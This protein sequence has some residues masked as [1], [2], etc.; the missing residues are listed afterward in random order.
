LQRFS[1]W[2]ESEIALGVGGSVM[3]MMMKKGDKIGGWMAMLAYRID[4]FFRELLGILTMLPDIPEAFRRSL[5]QTLSQTPENRSLPT[6]LLALC[7]CVVLVSLPRPLLRRHPVQP[8]WALRSAFAKLIV[9][10]L[11]D[12]IAL[13]TAVVIA[14]C[15]IAL[16]FTGEVAIDQL[17]V[18]VMWAVTRW[19]IA[20]LGI[21][22]FL[23]PGRPQIRLFAID[24]ATSLSVTRLM[25]WVF[26][27]ALSFVSI[28]PV[29]LMHELPLQPARALALVLAVVE[30][31]LCCLAAHR[32]ARAMPSTSG[33]VWLLGTFASLLFWLTW[34]GSVI[35]LDFTFY[36][37]LTE[38]MLIAWI[39]AALYAVGGLSLRP[40]EQPSPVSEP[41]STL[42]VLISC[43][44]RCLLV[45]GIAIGLLFNARRW[46]VEVTGLVDPEGWPAV[47]GSI[48]LTI[49]VAV[50]GYIIFEALRTWSAI[51]FGPRTT[52]IGFGSDDDEEAAHVG[53]RLA[54]I[55]PVLSKI[56]LCAFFGLAVL[57]GLSEYGV[58]I[59]PLLAGA[60]IFGL[61]ISFGSQALVRDIV[62]GFFFIIDDAFRIG[63]YIDT[64]RLKGTVERISLRSFRLR[65]QNGQVHTVPYGQIGAVTN[66]SRDWSTIKFNLRLA[67]NSD[68]ESVRKIAK[69]VGQEMLSDA[70]LGREFLAPLKLQGIADISENALILRFKFTVRPAK[71]STVQREAIK[72]LYAAFRVSKIEFA[73]T[74]VVVSTDSGHDLS[75]SAAAAH[76]AVQ[77]AAAD[78]PLA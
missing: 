25:G 55:L 51:R 1:T 27:F 21:N 11:N 58:N 69:R 15:S 30:L 37:A 34:M 57:L 73:T 66:F 7:T 72:R 52:N 75:E 56:L 14:G 33:R 28:V 31:P 45:I 13:G 59:A 22:V 32:L 26:A 76:A 38:M 18:G 17:A 3:M 16:F 4:G 50:T 70:E 43:V 54:T 49:L 6:T 53:S 78:N 2:R 62:S 5:V 12:L 77:S 36:D 24:E 65:H 23:R 35:A 8:A 39:I 20:M 41:S 48:S 71:V 10:T 61:A 74:S 67:R 64:G 47:A 9:A 63:E 29:L 40:P 46:A 68:L 60:G 19:Q 42:I 44:R